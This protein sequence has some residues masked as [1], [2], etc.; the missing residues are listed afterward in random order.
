MNERD[1]AAMNPWAG[2]NL[3][4]M[5]RPDR[6]LYGDHRTVDGHYFTSAKMREY[7][8]LCIMQE[9]DRCAR[10]ARGVSLN[11][12]EAYYGNKIAEAIEKQGAPR[13]AKPKKFDP[14]CPSGIPGPTY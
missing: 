9:R 2:A 3:P 13:L 6:T 10:I 12:E 8:L 1:D 11:D 4:P 5:I 7:G 14:D